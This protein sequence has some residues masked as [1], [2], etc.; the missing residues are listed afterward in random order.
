M[1]LRVANGPGREPGHCI[2]TQVRGVPRLFAKQGQLLPRRVSG[3]C[4][5]RVTRQSGKPGSD[6]SISLTQPDGASQGRI[7]RCSPPRRQGIDEPCSGSDCQGARLGIRRW[8]TLARKSP[9][10]LATAGTNGMATLTSRHYA[11]SRARRMPPY[12]CN[13]EAAS[14]LHRR[15]NRAMAFAMIAPTRSAAASTSRS[16]TW[17]YLSVMVG[18]A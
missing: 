17:A 2:T 1:C 4:I 16:P 12:R 11:R 6:A 14:G 7:P 10:P 3:C 18:C 13:P 8:R 9:D 5:R 15:S